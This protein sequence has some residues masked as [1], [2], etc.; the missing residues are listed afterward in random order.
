MTTMADILRQVVSP[1]KREAPVSESEAGNVE[2][3]QPSG[4]KTQVTTE[5][6]IQSQEV[7]SLQEKKEVKE[8]SPMPWIL[9]G[10][11]LVMLAAMS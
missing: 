11:A 6:A 8:S 9:G 2:E 4:S 7:L 3:G 1:G 5:A 10:G